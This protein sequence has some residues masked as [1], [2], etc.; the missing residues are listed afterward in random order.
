MDCIACNQKETMTKQIVI[1][2]VTHYGSTNKCALSS[3]SAEHQT[4]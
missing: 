3:H 1:M 2:A 4:P